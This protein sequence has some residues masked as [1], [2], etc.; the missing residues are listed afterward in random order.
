[1]KKYDFTAVQKKYRDPFS[2]H[3]FIPVPDLPSAMVDRIYFLN[4]EYLHWPNGA[5]LTKEDLNRLT[6]TNSSER[7]WSLTLLDEDLYFDN[8]DYSTGQLDRFLKGKEV[9]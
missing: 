2:G 8:I 3:T 4:K 1:M 7:Y 9:Y 5:Q 6:L